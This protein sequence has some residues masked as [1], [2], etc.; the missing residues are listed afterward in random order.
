MHRIDF[1]SKFREKAHLNQYW[2]SRHTIET[3]GQE[4]RARGGQQVAFLSTPSLFFAVSHDIP[5]CHLFDFDEEFNEPTSGRFSKF[6]YREPRVD[7]DHRHKYDM[8]VIDPPFITEEVIR[9]YVGIYHVLAKTPRTLLLFTTISENRTI[10]ETSLGGNVF[11]APFLPC[12]PNLVY[13]YHIF[14]NYE[15]QPESGLA[16]AN[17]EVTISD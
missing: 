6:D 9:A 11:V 16:A 7:T 2:Y 15:I 10:V 3:I 12:I 5:G 1:E 13:Q 4:L 17:P 8:V 14:T